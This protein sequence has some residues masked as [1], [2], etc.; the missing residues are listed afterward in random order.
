MTSSDEIKEWMKNFENQTMDFKS[1]QILSHAY[2][3]ADLMVAFANNKFVTKPYGGKIIIGIDDQHELEF[4]I[5]KQ[6]HEEHIV[7]IARDKCYPSIYP[8]FEKIDIENQTVYVITIP[9]MTTTPYQIITNYGKSHRIRVGSSIREP[10]IEEL[11]K[12]YSN[13]VEENVKPS[14]NKKLMLMDGPHRTF[15]VT[16][17][18]S[19]S[20]IIHFNNELINWLKNNKPNRIA[21]E[22]IKLIHD[23]IHYFHEYGNSK[24]HGIIDE[25][26]SISFRVSIPPEFSHSI[27]VNGNQ[28]HIKVISIEEESSFLVGI[29]QF[30]KVIYDKI[31]YSQRIKI[32]YVH[33]N[34]EQ[35]SFSSTNYKTPGYLRKHYLQKSEFE[36]SR[37]VSLDELNIQK[38][39]ESCLEEMARVCDWIPS[40]GY[41]EG[42]V[43]NAI[44]SLEYF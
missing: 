24:T 26:G 3:L 22:N 23:E 42:Y 18:N 17:K 31:E 28:K 41:F 10:T 35:Y 21:V 20:K 38:L 33:H 32:D 15:N 1:H 27:D 11:S 37:E 19:D 36:I 43:N 9:K 40:E 34:V 44:N 13:N 4:F 30:I 39:T 6:Q 8:E 25:Y 14:T 12:L 29:L 7:N 2:D 16:V 5:P